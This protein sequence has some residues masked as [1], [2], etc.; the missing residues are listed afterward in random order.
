[1]ANRTLIAQRALVLL[2]I[3]T[4][5]FS[6]RALTANFIRAHLDDAGWFPQD[7]YGT[8]DS[9]A[10]DWLDGRASIF[11]I[12]DSTRTDKAIYAPGYPLWLAFVYT[13]TGSRSPQAVQNLQWMMDSL[14]VLFI[15]GIGVTVFDWRVGLGAGVIA[16]IWPLLATYGAVPLADAP[17]SWIVLGAVWALLLAVKRKSLS[18]AIAAGALLGVSCWLRANALLLAFFWAAAVLLVV[19]ASWGRRFALAGAIVISALIVISP[20]V[21]RNAVVFRAFVPTGL[22]L[23]TNMLEGIGETE[24]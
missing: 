15:V 10:R 18:W 16:A 1:M 5:A 3:L 6:I 21:V 9:Q 8:F 22:G 17:T 14:S 4:I 24:R 12:D 11:W 2:F 23:G 13:L 7:I 19:S 20:I